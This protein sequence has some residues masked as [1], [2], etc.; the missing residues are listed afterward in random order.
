M[1]P[2]TTMIDVDI[3]KIKQKYRTNADLDMGYLEFMQD[4][5]KFFEVDRIFLGM[6]SVLRDECVPLME[7]LP[8]GVTNFFGEVTSFDNFSK[9]TAVAISETEQKYIDFCAD[10]NYFTAENYDELSEVLSQMG[11][12]KSNLGEVSECVLFC[13]QSNEAFSYFILERYGDHKTPWSEDLRL[14]IADVYDLSRMKVYINVLENRLYNDMRIKAEIV[15]NEKIPVCIVDNIQN[16]ILYYNEAMED[17]IPEI[18]L[19]AYYFDLFDEKE[20]SIEVYSDSIRSQKNQDGTMSYWIKKSLPFQLLDGTNV[21]MIYMKN[22]Q[23][24]ID[25][26]IG[27]DLLTSAYSLK[28]FSEAY[29]KLLL[30]EVRPTNYMLCAIDINKFKYINDRYTFEVGNRILQKVSTV[31]NHFMRCGEFFCRINEDKFAFILQCNTESEVKARLEELFKKLDEMKDEHFLDMKL[32]FVCGVTNINKELPINL[33]LDQANNARKMAKG[34]HKNMISFFD[35]E[36]EERIKEE[37]RIEQRIP[38]AVKNNEFIPFFTT[39]IRF[40]NDGN[41]RCRGSCAVVD[42]NRHDFP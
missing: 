18:G 39:K 19:G 28:G 3:F 24:Y 41:L 6:K 4:I 9:F 7:C 22:T 37:V 15:E 35:K 29:D 27:I 16:R 20:T 26:M 32:T 1:D 12:E 17:C 25:E 14:V 42:T 5:I 30:D 38:S 36:T 8:N 13:M 2:N 31:L 10:H 33:L 34:S 21:C 11:Y 40:A 23:D